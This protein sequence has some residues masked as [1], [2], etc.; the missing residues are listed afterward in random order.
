MLVLF[1]YGQNHI[2]SQISKEDGKM[3]GQTP[4]SHLLCDKS[5]TPVYKAR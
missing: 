1:S 4:Q 3:W 2:C 5:G